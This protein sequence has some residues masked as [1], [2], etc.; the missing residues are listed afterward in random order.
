MTRRRREPP[1][2]EAREGP[3]DPPPGNEPGSRPRWVY[4][5]VAAAGCLL[6]ALPY[7]PE[8]WAFFSSYDWIWIAWFGRL[9]VV[10]FWEFFSPHVVWF[11][12][13]LQ[14]FQF[15]AFFQ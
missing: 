15:A 8:L 2:P 5:S 10:R 12:R 6:A 1:T 13:P 3:E 7:L 4:A 11:Y 14:A 9:P